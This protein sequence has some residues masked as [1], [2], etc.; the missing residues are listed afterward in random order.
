[1]ESNRVPDLRDRTYADELKV[2]PGLVQ[3][4]T[5]QG[6]YHLKPDDVKAIKPHHRHKD[7]TC[8]ILNDRRVYVCSISLDEVR[9][10]FDAASL[11]EEVLHD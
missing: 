2:L 7:K 9:E 10:A 3:L 6:R 1:M 4:D 8:I 11:A 5:P